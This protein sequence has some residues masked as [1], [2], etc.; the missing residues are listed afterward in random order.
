MSLF[1]NY[2]N[3]NYTINSFRK[4]SCLVTTADDLA[5][6]WVLKSDENLVASID[7]EASF[8]EL[9]EK[10]ICEQEM[11]VAADGY[12]SE[13]EHYLAKFEREY[14]EDYENGEEWV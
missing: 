8:H 13:C 12:E 11:K 1:V 10:H 6:S 14:E 4:P 3:G 7:D 9:V 2:T 5:E